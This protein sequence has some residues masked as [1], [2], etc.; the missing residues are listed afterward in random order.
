MRADSLWWQMPWW[1][2]SGVLAS[3]HCAKHMSQLIQLQAV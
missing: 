2:F 3:V 1:C